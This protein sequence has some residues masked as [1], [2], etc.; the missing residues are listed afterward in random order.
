MKFV[1]YEGKKELIGGVEYERVQFEHHILL[2]R[3]KELGLTQQNVADLA[4][5]QLRQYQ[6]LEQGERNITGSRGHAFLSICEALKLDPYIFLNKGNEKPEK[7]YVVLPPLVKEG[8]QY[9]I[10]ELSY[11]LLVSAIPEGMVCTDDEI[12]QLLRQTY[13]SPSLEI[14]TNLNSAAL[15]GN[16]GFP[17]WRVVSQRGYLINSIYCSKERQREKLLSE[18]VKVEP[19]ESNDSY[20]VSEFKYCRFHI[21]RFIVSVLKDEKQ[22]VDEWSHSS[23]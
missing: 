1:Y 15:Y 23:I 7:K 8:L 4:G 3:R 22:L 11:Y 10:P 13:G 19:S 12:M 9:A 2:Q 5:L 20:R 18:G 21:D 17:F 6:R 14:K 16:D